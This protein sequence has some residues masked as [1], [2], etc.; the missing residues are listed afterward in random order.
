LDSE[1]REH[2]YH[3]DGGKTLLDFGCG[4]GEILA[5]IATH[6]D[7]A[8]GVDYSPSML[9]RARTLAVE[10]GLKNRLNLVL[11]DDKSVW[12]VTSGRFDRIMAGGVAQYLSPRALSALLEAAR[13]RLEPHGRI[14]LF[15]VIDARRLPLYDSG[16]L[17]ESNTLPAPTLAILAGAVRGLATSSVRRLRR[18]PAHRL[19]RSYT[20]A[21]L[22]RMGHSLG[23]EVET[24]CSM[25]YEYRF[26]AIFRAGDRVP[27]NRG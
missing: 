12:S 1:A 7:Q 2:L 8:V 16:L 17:R 22:K 14:A 11:A 27:A 6:Y 4:A 18:L 13:L 10:R 26:H 5:R 20:P 19:G 21:T 15:D 3:L 24:P 9:A 23:M 25:H